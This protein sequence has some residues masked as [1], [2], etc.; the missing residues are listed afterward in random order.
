MRSL[1]PK[2]PFDGTE[3]GILSPPALEFRHDAK[4]D[5]DTLHEFCGV[6]AVFGCPEAAKVAHL[7]LYALQHRGQESAG[8][9]VSDG[10]TVACYKGMGHVNELFTAEVLKGLPGHMAIGHT[11][12]STAGDTD[13]RNAQPLTV[14]CQKGQVALAHNGNLVNASARMRE[15]EYKGDIFQSTSDTEL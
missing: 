12:Y 6:F 5:D 1:G 11:R 4:L 3:E 9:A 2:K 8:I 15:L 13:L 14:S 10:L 7:G